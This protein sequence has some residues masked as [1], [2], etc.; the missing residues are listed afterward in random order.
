MSAVLVGVCGYGG[1]HAIPVHEQIGVSVN[2]HAI[3][4][5][6]HYRCVLADSVE[7]TLKEVIPECSAR[8]VVWS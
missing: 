4:C 8:A 7:R 6:N 2:H 3:W 1:A 5:V